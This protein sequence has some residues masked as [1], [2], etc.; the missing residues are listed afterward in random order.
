MKR[1]LF[2]AWLFIFL[3]GCASS[4]R[5]QQDIGERVSV[6]GRVYV[7]SISDFASTT[8]DA[9]PHFVTAVKSYLEQD[10]LQRAML[11]S[12]GMAADREV[13]VTLTSYRMRSG[14]NR[15]MFGVLAGKDGVESTVRVVDL[16][17]GELLGTS[18]VSSFNIMAIGQQ[19]DIARMHGKEIGKF[20][21]GEAGSKR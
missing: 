16:S 20:L 14:F 7:Y 1:G 12:E 4:T 3:G 10:L 8:T 17:T 6:D 21:A 13:Q 18:N 15:A 11:S 2:I 19:E 9:P 5:V